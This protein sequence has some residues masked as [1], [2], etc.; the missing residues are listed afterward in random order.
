[1]KGSGFM[2]EPELTSE[3][4]IFLEGQEEEHYTIR[5][6][7]Y[8]GRL[9]LSIVDIITAMQVSQRSPR[10]YW[11]QLK[12]RVKDEGFEEPGKKDRRKAHDRTISTNRSTE[13][14][15]V[16]ELETARRRSRRARLC[17]AVPL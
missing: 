2:D 3:L 17:R 1:M 15:H 12:E 7:W 4:I 9:Y 10:Q 8:D 14:P 16:A 5:K 6:V 11:A 13:R